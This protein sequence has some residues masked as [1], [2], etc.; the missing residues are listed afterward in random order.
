[1]KG[2]TGHALT[3]GIVVYAVWLLLSGHYTPLLLAI[4]LIGTALVVYFALRMEFADE[5]G[6]PVIHLSWRIWG[7]LPW[8]VLEIVKSNIAVARIVLDPKLPIDPIMIRVRSRQRTDLGKVIMA[9]S[10]TL[11]PGTVTV[12]MAGNELFVHALRASTAQGMDDGEM[13][14][15]VSA[16][17]REL[18]VS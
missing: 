4:G 6:V 2:R 17:E 11:T 3:L 16:L 7:Y 9:N 15:R 1:M 8:L 12:G 5:E 10:I 13:N 14:V 18:A